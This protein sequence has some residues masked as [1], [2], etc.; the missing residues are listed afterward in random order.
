MYIV[1]K[2]WRTERERETEEDRGISYAFNA[3]VRTCVYERVVCLYVARARA[4]TKLVATSAIIWV[5]HTCRDTNANP[6]HRLRDGRRRSTGTAAV[7][8]FP[9][10]LVSSFSRS[11]G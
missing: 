3:I 11:S 2:L 9:R 4:R 7:M 10:L 6:N 1:R 5:A 8:E